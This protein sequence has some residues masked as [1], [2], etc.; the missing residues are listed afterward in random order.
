MVGRGAQ[1]TRSRSRSVARVARPRRAAILHHASASAPTGRLAV[2]GIVIMGTMKEKIQSLP[3]AKLG[4]AGL[5][6]LHPSLAAVLARDWLDWRRR[7]L[8]SSRHLTAAIKWICGAQDRGG[9][10][11]VSAGYSIVHGSHPPYPETT[12]YII[13]KLFDYARLTSSDKYRARVC[14]MADWELKVQLPS[15]AAQG[16]LCRGGVCE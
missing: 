2:E 12:G 7:P 3:T 11:G 4:R 8:D 6:L 16:G 10:A 15:G 9:G 5:R 14:R 13:P 1:Q